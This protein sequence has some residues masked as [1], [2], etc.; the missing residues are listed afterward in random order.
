MIELKEVTKV[1]PGQRQPAVAD[2]SFTVPEGKTCVLIGPSGCGKTTIMKMVN[3]L[4][5]PTEGHIF[6]NGQSAREMNPVKLRRTI[7]Y[8]IQQIGLFPHMTIQQNIAVVPRLLGWKRA[9]IAQRTDELIELVG[10][11]P[12]I[13]RD[14]YPRELSG[15]Q[16]QRIGVARALA[17]DPPVM[18]MDEPFGAVDPITR[19]RLQN[20]F[21][22]LQQQLH[23]TVV[24]VTHD[25]DEAVKMGDQI[26]ILQVGG[27][28]QQ[29]GS[30]DAILA[31]P[32][33]DFVADFVGSDRGLKRLSLIRVGEVYEQ[34]PSA[35]MSETAE[36]AIDRMK[37]NNATSVV[38]LDR[39][40]HVLG[41]LTLDD[42]ER[43][44]H[45]IV[46]DIMNPLEVYSETQA[47]L[48]D[49]FSEMLTNAIRILPVVDDQD[50]YL[51]TVTI[52]A[53]QQA[54]LQA[55]VDEDEEA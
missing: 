11:D 17:V 26:V 49:A 51:G 2:V 3:R 10:M 34:Y 28:I 20:E 18:L 27:A 31:D 21:L 38:V 19:D 47:T 9:K 15:G 25:I 52:D 22:R 23:K 41:Y 30:P 55:K 4:I 44:H 39:E 29:I 24:F 40:K 46:A 36:A 50:R 45:R 54:I 5:E 6:V 1:Y 7:G 48:R 13:Y 37:R 43:H 33:N 42:A 53:A 32:A 14:R 12:D 16:R 8:V 35:Q